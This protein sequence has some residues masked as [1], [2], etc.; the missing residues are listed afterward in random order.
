M[1]RF[2]L[3]L[4]TSLIP[5]ALAV[6]QANGAEPFAFD[7]Y[8]QTCPGGVCPTPAP[9]AK[10]RVAPKGQVEV[11]GACRIRGCDCGCRQGGLCLCGLPDASGVYGPYS[12]YPPARIYQRPHPARRAGPVIRFR[13]CFGGS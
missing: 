1:N 5:I 2:L 10:A 13:N 4:I 12:T 3:I 9:K 6:I 11:L 7:P 8:A